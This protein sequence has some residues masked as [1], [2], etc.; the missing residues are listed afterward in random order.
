MLH[1]GGGTSSERKKGH[2]SGTLQDTVFLF[3]RRPTEGE[4]TFCPLLEKEGENQLLYGGGGRRWFFS[5]LY[6][7]E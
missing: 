7:K 6:R 1:T 3:E 2:L 4:K 5:L